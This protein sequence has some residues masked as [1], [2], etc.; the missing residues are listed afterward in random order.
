[1]RGEDLGAVD[2][3]SIAVRSGAGLEVSDRG[4]RVG[5]GHAD[6]DDGFAAQEP[7]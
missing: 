2:A 7:F 3:E 6:G 5:L 1:M 4:A